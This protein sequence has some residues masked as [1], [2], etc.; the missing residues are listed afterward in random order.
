MKP[1]SLVSMHYEYK[2]DAYTNQ[3]T[4]IQTVTSRV[5]SAKFFEPDAFFTC[6]FCA[7]SG[8]SDETLWVRSALLGLPL[9]CFKAS[10]ERDVTFSRQHE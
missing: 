1:L 2:P 9:K 6:Q 5:Q 10:Q 8:I 7:I 4:L 3:Q